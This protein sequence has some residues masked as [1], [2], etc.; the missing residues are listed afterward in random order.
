MVYQSRASFAVKSALSSMSNANFVWL[1]TSGL[2]SFRT[3]LPRLI[4][5]ERS[6]VM[7]WLLSRYPSPFQ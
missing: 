3:W 2:G 5:M 6:T 7:K 1:D 4:E